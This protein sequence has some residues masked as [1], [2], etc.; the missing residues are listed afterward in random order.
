[1]AD[2]QGA[3]GDQGQQQSGEQQGG[4]GQQQQNGQQGGEQQQG[5][6]QQGEQQQQND[7]QQ[8]EPWADPVKA[9]AEIE[10]L[11]RER[12]DERMNAKREA[13]NE[14]FIA[15]LKQ[16][17]TEAEL[18][19]DLEGKSADQIIDALKQGLTSSGA[20]VQERDQA[21]QQARDT[22]LELAVVR[23]AWKQGVDPKKLDY[24]S[25]TLTRR[26]DFGQ[27]DPTASDF[28]GKL[29]GVIG[30]A[31][32][33]DSSLKLS[34]AAQGTGAEQFGGANGSTALTKEQFAALPL[35][36]KSRLYRENR[37]E[38]DRLSAL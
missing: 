15:G 37:S 21:R 20:A 8:N 25:F 36:E 29:A 18:G 2:G 9:R 30:Q 31:I 33:E 7:Q 5:S 19:V 1:M 3:G 35:A 24:L 23:E 34:G 28:S 12:G 16:F 32:T 27:L 6:Q 13:R 17:A 4:D 22:Q 38:F 10:R 26:D 14:G 11:R